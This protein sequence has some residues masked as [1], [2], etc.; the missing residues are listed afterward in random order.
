MDDVA[1]DRG[2][3]ILIA[4]LVLA[5][6]L[7][8][9]V[10]ILNAAIYT[11]NVATRAEATDSGDAVAF[12]ATVITDTTEITRQEATVEDAERPLDTRIERALERYAEQVDGHA[13]AD[14]TQAHVRVLDVTEGV[15]T[16]EIRYRTSQTHYEDVVDVGESG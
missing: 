7:V 16:I 2:Q 13:T 4:G 6:L 14:A 15:A 9:M 12:R 11:E 8:A 3:L 5:T 1:S 10:L